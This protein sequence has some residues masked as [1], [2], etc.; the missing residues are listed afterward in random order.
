MPLNTQPPPQWFH[1]TALMDKLN[2]LARTAYQMAVWGGIYRARAAMYNSR[3][4]VGARV[5]AVKM[6]I[7]NSGLL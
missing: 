5:D 6:Y 7:Q 3:T 1:L 2:F 4:D